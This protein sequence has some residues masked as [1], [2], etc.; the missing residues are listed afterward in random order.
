V[1]K[2]AVK[3]V[4]DL[5]L[6]PRR[7][8]GQ[9]SVRGSRPTD[10]LPLTEP[11]SEAASTPE[12]ATTPFKALLAA[13]SLIV[14]VLAVAGFS[15]RWNYY[16]NFGLQN[17]V[18]QTP[19]TTLPIYAIEI[20]RNPQNIV[21][22][23]YYTLEFL[24][25][26]E[27]LLVTIRWA[28]RSRW[29]LFASVGAMA[30]RLLGQDSPLVVD[31]IRAGIIVYIAF[32]VGGMAGWRDFLANVVEKTSPLPRVA[33]ML[34]SGQG[35]AKETVTRLPLICDTRPLSER[36]RPGEAA[37]FGDPAMIQTPSALACSSQSQTWRLLFRDDKFIYLF[38]TIPNPPGPSR[39]SRP[40]Q[41]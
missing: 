18:L 30:T 7:V 4:V 3:S 20:V 1:V 8:Q 25:P 5:V 32:V 37:F 34:L 15:S 24:L 17:L 13:W 23:L 10:K 35:D 16:Y 14:V 19:L 22:L 31:V 33:V 40:S 11:A 28:R 12:T 26:F 9:A 29:R 2:A 6:M 41:Q 39:H 36:S 27:I 21:S 38:T